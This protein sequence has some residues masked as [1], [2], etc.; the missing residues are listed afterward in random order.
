MAH[1]RQLKETAQCLYCL[2]K[3][4]RLE[5]AN[6]DTLWDLAEIYKA[7]GEKSKVI[8]ACSD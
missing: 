3:A 1:G 4:L 5:P 6:A 2:R 8:R 7:T